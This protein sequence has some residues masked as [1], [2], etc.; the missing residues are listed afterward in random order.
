MAFDF[1]DFNPAQTPQSRPVNTGMSRGTF[2]T[3][4]QINMGEQLYEHFRN[5]VPG[6]TRGKVFSAI[7]SAGFERPDLEEFV[8]EYVRKSVASKKVTETLSKLR[9][10]NPE[11]LKQL[12]AQMAALFGEDSQDEEV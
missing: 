8:G 2:Y 6:L 9:Q 3:H 5:E 7:V 1:K 10:M 11:E 12:K 4:E